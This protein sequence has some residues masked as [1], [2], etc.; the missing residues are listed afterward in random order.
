MFL[1]NGGRLE[2]RGGFV[3]SVGG[4]ILLRDGHELVKVPEKS[5][6]KFGRPLSDPG[7]CMASLANRYRRCVMCNFRSR[8]AG[9]RDAFSIS[10]DVAQAELEL[11]VDEASGVFTF[12]A[13]TP[14]IQAD[15]KI[16][17]SKE[18]RCSA[19]QSNQ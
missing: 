15:C 2:F 17:I 6:V 9:K 19:E 10:S 11:A 3:S 4:F 8:T 13:W 1:R 12:H 7:P 14:T 18:L 16:G 5:V